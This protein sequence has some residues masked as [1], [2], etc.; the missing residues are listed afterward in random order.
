MGL[1]LEKCNSLWKKWTQLTLTALSHVSCVRTRCA[2]GI[3]AR[4][5]GEHFLLRK[6]FVGLT[7]EGTRGGKGATR[8]GR[9]DP[10]GGRS[11]RVY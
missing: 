10:G 11:E 2:A 6:G 9:G 1:G 5:K 3:M 7:L 8:G 4:E